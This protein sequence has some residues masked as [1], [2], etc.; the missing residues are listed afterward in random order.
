M[1]NTSENL[2]DLLIGHSDHKNWCTNAKVLI[3]LRTKAMALDI[4]HH[5]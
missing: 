2:T 1:H 5:W 3:P 4:N